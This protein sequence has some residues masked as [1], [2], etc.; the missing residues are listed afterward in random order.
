MIKNIFSRIFTY[1]FSAQIQKYEALLAQKEQE[2]NVL[3]HNLATDKVLYQQNILELRKK[4][5]ELLTENELLKES[6]E[7]ILLLQKK[8]FEDT[9]KK[10]QANEK[11]LLKALEKLKASEALTKSKTIELEE[12]NAQILA[13]NEELHKNQEEILAQRDF[14]EQKNRELAERDKQVSSSIS[15][16]KTI[17]HA[18]LPLGKELATVFKEHFVIYQPKDIVSGDFYWIAKMEN[19]TVLVVADCTGHGVPG[20]FTSLIGSILL[21][22]IVRVWKITDPAEILDKLH[23]EVKTTLRQ[24]DT[25]N[26][27][28][29]DVAIVTITDYTDNKVNILFAGAKRPLWYVL[30]NT[31]EI[32]EIKGERKAIGGIQNQNKAFLTHQLSL[33][34]GTTIFLGSD[35]F[36]DQCNAQRIN[37]SEKRLKALISENINEPLEKQKEV[38]L[39]ALK[40][41]SV[42][43]LQRDD[44]MLFGFKL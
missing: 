27:I 14:I 26:R 44:I 29:M 33:E 1:I 15:V 13:Q 21:D 35:G 2:I 11:V 7:E 32:L 40:T 42:G 17:Q 4:E 31:Q 37:F 41:Y 18:I 23:E 8:T 19:A 20:A 25:D 30:P 34:K 6:H 10:I 28:G 3:T 39:E 38:Y 16:A 12:K 24:E 22:K 36:T 5:Q 9:T 43:T